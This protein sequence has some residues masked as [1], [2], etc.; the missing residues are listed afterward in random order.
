[1]SVFLRPPPGTGHATSGL[2]APPPKV[3]FIGALDNDA[4]TVAGLKARLGVQIDVSVDL[5]RVPMRAGDG[6]LGI[7]LI[8]QDLDRL[9]DA[10][11]EQLGADRLLVPHQPVIALGL[12]LLGHM[13][14]QRVGRGAVDILIFEAADARELGFGKPIEQQGEVLLGLAGEA[15]R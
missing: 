4:Q 8:D 6:A 10:R 7:D 11:G 9:A 5:R 1:M 12:D 2:G 15:R 3:I 14:G 13:A